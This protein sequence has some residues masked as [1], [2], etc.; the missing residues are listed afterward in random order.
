MNGVAVLK[1]VLVAGVAPNVGK[2]LVFKG[3]KVYWKQFHSGQRVESMV[4]PTLNPSTL[5]NEHEPDLAQLWRSL[6]HC[7][8]QADMLCLDSEGSLASPITMDTTLATLAKEWRMPVLL[9]VPVA[10]EAI[11]PT[12]AILALAREAKTTVIGIVLNHHVAHP[13]ISAE[14]MAEVLQA[15]TQVSILGSMPFLPEPQ[16]ED[17]LARGIS[18]LML[19]VILDRIDA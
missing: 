17:K 1:T 13:D 9:V 15:L 11:A 7:Q 4:L 3:L 6:R 19:D 16:D 18:E 12:A 10:W 5:D 14:A 2:S 8:Q